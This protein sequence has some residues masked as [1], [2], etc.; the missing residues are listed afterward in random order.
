LNGCKIFNFNDFGR[1]ERY[2][3]LDTVVTVIMSMQVSDVSNIEGNDQS[4][5]WLRE[6]YLC[7]RDC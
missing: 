6:L 2:C 5:I 3:V 7:T 1:E 4:W